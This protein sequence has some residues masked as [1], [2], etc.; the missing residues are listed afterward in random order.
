MGLLSGKSHIFHPQVDQLIH[1]I[2]VEED[3]KASGESNEELFHASGDA[4]EKLYKKGDFAKSQISKLDIY[5]L[6]KVWKIF[7]VLCC[8]FSSLFPFIEKTK[9]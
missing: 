5:L 9:H 6:R 3:A 7:I 2:L 8:G 1:R 4:G